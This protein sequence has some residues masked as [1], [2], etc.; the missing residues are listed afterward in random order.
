MSNQPEVGQTNQPEV[1]QTQGLS[2]LWANAPLVLVILLLLDSLHFIFAR[3]LIPYL[4]GGTSAFFVLAV[5]TVEVGVYLGVKRRIRFNILRANLP[6]FLAIGLLVAASTAFNYIAV[7][8]IDP[9]TASLLSR[10]VTVF[11]LAFSIVWLHERLSGLEIPGAIIAVAG[12]FII[13][14]QPGDY[15][16]LGA[17][18]VVASA[19]MYAM[20]A[21]IV[22]RYGGQMDFGNFFLFRVASVT[23]FLLLFTTARGQLSW[24][25]WE[26]WRFLLLAGTIDVVI[27][28][29]LYYLA[30]RRLQ[31]SLHTIILTLSPVITVIWAMLLF[32]EK[33]TLQSFV[34]GAAVILGVLVVTWSKSRAPTVT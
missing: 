31:M 1:G 33:P 13:S 14:F 6:F 27:S 29:V 32:S 18:L 20:H 3:L 21:A 8:Y 16:R 34:G 26:A 10:S 22:K 5:A 15:L 28:R 25:S 11:A 4:P 23:G 17:L 24:P 7:G 12:V 9:G 30:L 19:F 2:L